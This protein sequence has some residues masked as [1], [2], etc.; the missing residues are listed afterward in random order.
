MPFWNRKVRQMS[1]NSNLANGLAIVS[2]SRTGLRH[3]DGS[4]DIAAY[5][6]IAHRDRDA[7]IAS[8]VR[9][10]ATIRAIASAVWRALGRP[11]RTGLN[12]PLRG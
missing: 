6:R 5:A 3:P 9:K 11:G 2:G 7:A 12:A 8:T 10:A 1:E 4:I